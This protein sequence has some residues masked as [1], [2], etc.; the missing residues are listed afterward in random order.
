MRESKDAW[1]I[2][3]NTPISAR[4]HAKRET[5]KHLLWFAWA[6]TLLSI[7]AI[8]FPEV[9]LFDSSDSYPPLHT[10]LEFVPMV[11]SAMVFA[12]CW[13]L[14]HIQPNSHRLWIGCSLL[15][16]GLV[17]LAH[18]LSYAGMPA[19]VTASSPEKAINFWLAGRFILAAGFIEISLFRSR[20]YNGSKR[21]SL[22]L[23]VVS[24]TALIWWIGLWH[25]SLL[26]RTYIQGQGLTPFK[27]H[28]EYLLTLLYISAAAGLWW[29]YRK[30]TKNYELAI[31]SLAAWVLALAE[32]YLTLYASVS[33][34]FNLLGHVYKTIG[35]LFIYQ[36]I[37]LT[38]VNNPYIE[39]DFQRSRLKTLLSTLNDLI[40]LKDI[41]GEYLACNKSFEQFVG[42]KE[43]DII[44]KTDFDLFDHELATMFRHYD[45]QALHRPTPSVNEEFLTFVT[46]GYAGLFETTKTPLRS[47][48]GTVIGVLGLAHDIT[49]RKANERQIQESEQHYRTL[50]NCGSALIWTSDT[51]GQVNYVN[52]TWVHFTGQPAKAEWGNGWQQHIHPEDLGGCIEIFADARQRQVRFTH[53]FRLRRHDEEYRWLR[54]DAS[55]RYDS[56]QQFLGFIGFC[57]DITEQRQAAEQISFMAFHDSLT[58]LP[59]RRLMLDRLEQ[60]LQ[61]SHRTHTVGALILI[62][63]D[64]FKAL[65]DTLGHKVGDQILVALT[66]RLQSNL[67]EGNTCA[68]IG[69]DEFV[70]LTRDQEGSIHAALYAENVVSRLQQQLNR[71]YRLTSKDATGKPV[72]HLYHC[73]TSIGIC[74][75]GDQILLPDELLKRAETAM[76]QAKAAGRNT[77]RFFDPDMQ[78][79]IETQARME[80]DLREALEQQQ[81]R[82][83]LQPQVNMSGQIIGAEALIRWFHPQ[84]GVI[85]PAEFIPV[86]ESCG[87]IIPIGQWVLTTACQLL[88]L[89]QHHPQLS[90][91]TLSVNVSSM[92]F[93]QPEFVTKVVGV[94]KK[95][96]APAHK[97]KL[98]LTES[99]L[100]DNP[101][102]V[103][104]KMR[105]LQYFGLSFSLD[106]F[107]TGYSSLSYLKRLPLDQ[108]KIDRSFVMDITTDSNAAAI[109]RTIVVLGQNLGLTVVAEGVEQIEQQAFLASNGCSIYQGYLYSPPLE[110]SH[111]EQLVEQHAA[112]PQQYRQC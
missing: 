10:L 83:F 44:G 28:A 98:E 109:A 94:L 106:D 46:T 108:L 101:D 102:L 33:D 30:N 69:G 15:A 1:F 21:F 41:D 62:D 93:A 48:D 81:F 32:L 16:T 61:I 50:A 104:E 82:L 79:A 56:E 74:L 5:L 63:L 35:Y 84:R 13:S 22:L 68:R 6:L 17:D 47:S 18:T 105:E 90:Q 26:P 95:A 49:L 96:G 23:G 66:T 88:T 40:W 54:M 39:L 2:P 57:M 67:S 45:M 58:G 107:G 99:M 42:A 9:K 20:Y 77:Y 85:S 7:A 14:R 55:P 27:V 76:Y 11:I 71:P 65:N 38:G 80:N 36:A 73:T 31:L 75:F 103:A 111:F 100:V 8:W 34:L 24:I 92:Q 97:L 91:L 110:P 89:W 19:F 52:D 78:A 60:L 70:I 37:F 64:N 59:N 43:Q 12:L 25:P 87:L 51:T 53:E 112:Q 3:L 86:A 4:R 72:D 29:R